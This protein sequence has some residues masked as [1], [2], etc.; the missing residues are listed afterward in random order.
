MEISQKDFI[1]VIMKTNGRC[2]YCNK[3]GEVVDHFFPIKLWKEFE[4]WENG[5]NKDAIENLFLSCKRCN[6]IKR[7]KF[8]EDFF[9][10]K[11]ICYDRYDRAN[12][13]I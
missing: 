13:R 2:F 6:Q 11:Y 3:P 10:S 4:L 9:G 12:K 5:I 8:P 1:K 7:D